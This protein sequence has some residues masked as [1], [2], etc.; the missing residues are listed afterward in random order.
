MMNTQKIL[1]SYITWIKDNTF[2]DELRS[3]AAKVTVPFMD[4]HNDHLEIYVQEMDG[5]FILTDD[6]YTINDLTGSGF[7]LNTPKRQQIFNT[8]VKGYG[9]Q[10]GER[11]QLFTE[12]TPQNIGQKKHY[13]IQAM[14]AVNDMYNLAQENVMSLFK[15]DVER[16]FKTEDVLY[17]KDI[18][19]TGKSGFD[20]YI[21]FI[22]PRTRSKPERLIKTMNI[23]K[24]D[25]ATSA[26]FAFNDISDN[27]IDIPSNNIVIFND[28][29]HSP[30]PDVIDAFKA[31]KVN[32]IPWSRREEFRSEFLTQ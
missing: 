17:T 12:A 18:K 15:E 24:K 3:S 30:S 10:I 19:L 7:E 26:I 4:R 32:G 28:L 29:A 5:K 16:F 21:D 31:Y 6:G 2:A 27:R 14:L 1:N 23:A 11:F 8:T 25:N 13:L 22:V 20:H 9:V